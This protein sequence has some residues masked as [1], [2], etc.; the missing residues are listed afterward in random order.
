VLIGVFSLLRNYFSL[1]FGMFIMLVTGFA[2]LLLYRQ[3]KAVWALFAGGYLTYMGALQ[4]LGWIGIR[5]GG[6]IF[7]GMFF[8]VPGIIFMVA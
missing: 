8:I 7:A 4:V 5:L 3:K 2:L 6:V 1:N